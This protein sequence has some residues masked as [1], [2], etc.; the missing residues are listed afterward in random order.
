MSKPKQSR[1]CTLISITATLGAPWQWAFDPAVIPARARDDVGGCEFAWYTQAEGPGMHSTGFYIYFKHS[2]LVIGSVTRARRDIFDEFCAYV[3]ATLRLPDS[4]SFDQ[5]WK[6]IRVHPSKIASEWFV[7]CTF[8][9]GVHGRITI[10]PDMCAIRASRF[11]DL[12]HLAAAVMHRK[13]FAPVGARFFGFDRDALIDLA[14][15]ASRDTEFR[16]SREKDR[17]APK[18]DGWPP[19]DGR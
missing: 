13:P 10:G 8:L 14:P 3:R 19:I 17:G 5:G 9:H 11:S 18:E 7:D 4:V 1:G 2:K 6:A 16:W 15:Y 12:E